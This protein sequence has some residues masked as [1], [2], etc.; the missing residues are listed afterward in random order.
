MPQRVL[1]A[2]STVA[3]V[4]GLAGVSARSVSF[5]SFLAPSTSV[6]SS[7]FSYPLA[8]GLA[9]P[10]AGFVAAGAAGLLEATV[11]LTDALQA[12][13]SVATVRRKLRREAV[14]IDSPVPSGA[15]RFPACHPPGYS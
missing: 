14:V 2:R 3:T 4:S 1:K 9:P 13:S 15:L 7:R 6:W 12:V 8:A 11:G 10:A 5:D